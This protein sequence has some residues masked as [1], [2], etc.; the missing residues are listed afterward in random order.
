MCKFRSKPF[1]ASLGLAGAPPAAA[2]GA[3]AR[4]ARGGLRGDA[5][6]RPVPA[7]VSC[8]LRRR[9]T[10][11]V[12]CRSSSVIAHPFPVFA[13]TPPGGAVTR[14]EEHTSELQSLA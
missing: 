12:E 9:P 8:L 3:G 4:G 6:T 13:T 1:R 11:A 5:Q 2:R 14:S 7:A 10:L